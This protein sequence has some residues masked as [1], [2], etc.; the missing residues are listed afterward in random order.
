MAL[1]DDWLNSYGAIAFADEGPRRTCLTVSHNQAVME[2]FPVFRALLSELERETGRVLSEPA[3]FAADEPV[4]IPV[5]VHVLWNEDEQNIPDA[6][7]ASQIETLNADF[8]ARNPDRAGIPAVWRGLSVDSG[9]QFELARRDPAGNPHTGINRVKTGRSGFG[10]DDGAKSNAD[11]GTDAWPAQDYL[12]IWV[13]NL[14]GGVLG[15]A[16][17]PGG[18]PVTDGVVIGHRFFGSG[19][20]ARAPFDNGRTATHEVGHWL[21]LRHIWGDTEDCSGSD[22]V[23]DTPGQRLP[24]Y[25]RPT[26]PSVSCG[27]GPSGDMF[28]NYMDYVDDTAM[29]MFTSGQVARMKATLATMRAGLAA[30]AALG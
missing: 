28:M 5:V 6:Q 2:R 9:I 17:F 4:T 16:Q 7:I 20:S 8:A 13:C 19:G 18:P 27:N 11:G 25:G 23:A 26:F 29:F 3:P 30:S 14:E 10:T 21:N 12:N 1:Q 22:H 15:Y 24:N